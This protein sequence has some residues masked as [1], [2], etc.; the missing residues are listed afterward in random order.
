MY[1]VNKLKLVSVLFLSACS[2][3]A[4]SIESNPI[5]QY[6]VGSSFQP[7]NASF[8]YVS[9]LAGGTGQLWSKPL[10]NT[11][12]KQLTNFDEHI[13]KSVWHDKSKTL[14]IEVGVN[15]SD[16][17][18]I[19]VGDPVKNNFNQISP[20]NQIS[21]LQ[22]WAK[23]G[24]RVI[25]STRSKNEKGVNLVEFDLDTKH[26]QRLTKSPYYESLHDTNEHGYLY[27]QLFQRSDENL[28]LKSDSGVKTLISHDEGIGTIKKAQ[29]LND[30]RVL[31][32][33]DMYTDRHALVLID[34]KNQR[35]IVIEE[36]DAD[37]VDINLSPDGNLLF[38]HWQQYSLSNFQILDTAEFSVL[39]ESKLPNGTLY[40]NAWSHDS[41]Y[42]SYQFVDDSNNIYVFDNNTA[43]LSQQTY[44]QSSSTTQTITTEL[45]KFKSFD[46][47]QLDGWLKRASEK[48]APTVIYFHGG[49]E[50]ESTFSGTSDMDKL[51]V[52]A[53]INVFY[54]N[55]RG[56]SGRGKE[57][58]TL[59]NKEKRFDAIKDVKA[60]HD[61]LVQEKIAQA[62]NIAVMGSSYGGYM[63]NA[64]LAFHPKLFATGISMYGISDFLSNRSWFN[65]LSSNEYGDPTKDRDLLYALSPV[66][67]AQNIIAPMLFINGAED[68]NTP[69]EQSTLLKERLDAQ[70]I[71][72]DIII[73]EDEGH[74]IVK[75]KNRKR[76]N[77]A[78]RDWL[79]KHF[80]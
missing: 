3:S 24:N 66:N 53:G 23:T 40:R 75:A 38:V 42:L 1:T 43:K 13:Y 56:S 22:S 5:F 69:V 37:V 46:N 4:K 36:P 57:F 62:G 79:V 31:A 60:I 61:Y 35:K 39:Y 49:P 17:R 64:S 30:G 34:N 72:T 78:I 58:V 2:F 8:T 51:L 33:T 15:G 44:C 59:D 45:H 21:R 65:H 54:P 41:R 73:F 77:K 76:M 52:E 6:C 55:I 48:A 11:W 74:G 70:G 71:E 32:A 29:L 16:E 7:D 9:N 14:A 10:G 20:S 25:Y 26:S 18:L 50:R 19:L 80:N 27:W 68:K 63:T 47:L 67:S 12:P 28:L